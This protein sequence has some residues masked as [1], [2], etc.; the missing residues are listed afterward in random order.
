MSEPP[1]FLAELRALV[2][3]WSNSA[4]SFLEDRD[5]VMHR[6][7][8]FLDARDALFARFGVTI[9]GVRKGFETS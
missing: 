3:D 1:G 4:P 2:S 8:E 6:A 7:R 9:E 5:N